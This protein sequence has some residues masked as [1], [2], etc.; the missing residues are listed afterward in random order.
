VPER[1]RSADPPSTIAAE[2]SQKWKCMKGEGLRV[3]VSVSVVIAGLFVSVGDAA[4]QTASPIVVAAGGNLQAALN[5]AQPGQVVEVQAGATFDGNFLLPV[6]TGTGY[7][8]VRTSTPDAHLPAANARIGPAHE[9][10]LPT[11]RSVNTMPALRTAAGARHWRL[12]GLRF[13]STGGG[14]VISLGDGAQQNHTLVPSD[15]ILDRV[16]VRGDA[17]RGQKRGIALNSAHT[18]ILNSHI[19]G[20]RLAGQE[21][22]AIAGWNGPGPF[23]I[24]NNYIEAAAIG[25]LFGGAVPA[26][27]QLV[28]SDIVIRRNLISRPVAWRGGAW[29]VKNLLELKNARNVQIDGNV[30]ENNWAAD[31]SGFALVFT[32][33]ASGAAPWTTIEHVRVENNVVRHSGSAINI[34]GYDN[35][36]PSR[37]LR[38]LV[39]RNNL[40]TDI[41]QG[42]WGGAGIFVQMGDEPADVH[43]EHNTVMH[44][45]HVVSVYGGTPAARRVATGFRFVGNIVKHNTSGIVG[46]GVGTGNPA[47]AAYLPGSVI[48]GNVIAGG[49][50]NVYPT[51]N[52][53]PTVAS[54]MAQFGNPSTDDYRLLAASSLRSLPQGVPG[55][56]V[57]ALQRAM[58]GQASTPPSAPTGLRI[59]N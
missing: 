4:G 12:V 55:V 58:S 13:T 42:A 11:L 44:S 28:P 27:D 34:L 26:I 40:F 39:I 24:E 14:D 19:A 16:I 5:Q 37:Q 10:L 36:S 15:L 57:D 2:R 20:I 54:L 38:D 53:F 46:D 1:E 33:R 59:I 21:S 49:N 6:K 9:S 25:V 43:V 31:Q 18:Q 48:V 17:A 8:T 51:G 23:V 22:Q 7:I 50:A 47:I 32:V 3:A 56:D 52:V 45:G 29:M 41:D 30:I 35:L